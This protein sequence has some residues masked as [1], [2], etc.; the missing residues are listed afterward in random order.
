MTV[1]KN[2][3]RKPEAEAERGVPFTVYRLPLTAI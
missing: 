3:K 1:N 2:G